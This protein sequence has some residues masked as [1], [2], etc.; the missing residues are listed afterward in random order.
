M[1]VDFGY[2]TRTEMLNLG[3]IEP[4]KRPRGS[5]PIVVPK[6]VGVVQFCIDYRK[7]KVVSK[8]NTYPMPKVGDLLDKLGG[9]AYLSSL[10]IEKGIGRSP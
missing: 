2:R 8:F 6:P 4:A 3:V 10:I 1:A 9:E 5:Y 7:V